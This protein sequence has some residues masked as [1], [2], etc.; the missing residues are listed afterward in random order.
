MRKRTRSRE[1]VLQILY[2]LEIRGN[3]VIDEVDAFCIEQGKEAEVSDFAIK[4]AKGC[5]PK[6][7]EIDQKIIDISKNWELQRMPVVD[8]NILR[9]ACYELFYMDD[10]PPKVSINEAIDLAKKYSTE[11][12]GFFVN[13]VLDK[14]YSINIKNDKKDQKIPTSIEGVDAFDKEDRTG[15]DL[16][17][18]T[19][20]SDGTMSPGQVVKEASKLNLRTIAITDHDNVD[21]V[22]IAQI[23]GDMEGVNVIPAIELSSYY[24]PAD[25]H[26]LGYYI[27]TKNSALIEKLAELR[28]ERVERIKKI[29]KKLRAIGVKVEHQEVFDVS[30]EGSPGRMHIADVLCSKG[31]CAN[32]RETFKKYL[33]DN[34][35][36]F[37]P[38]VALTLKDAIELIISSD[39]IPVLAHPGVTKRDTLIPKMVEYGLQGI[40]VYYPTHQPDAVKR[41]KRI[42]K[43]HDLVITGGSDCHGNRK[44]EIALGSTKIS[45]D[46]VDK[47]K[48]R[49]GNAV[50]ALI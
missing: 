14:I 24:Q 9:L 22:E 50:G 18:H 46:L 11:K 32:I 20:L 10:V 45:D 6:I 42:A 40:E 13:G 25:I 47:I 2:Q 26:L 29:T 17:I 31:Y 48:E 4:L 27:D 35:P 36:A 37:V 7:E 43:K 3:E 23:V 15:A 28:L 39:G 1:I 16:H 49:R 38:K 44:P 33:S 41:Y 8:K 21:A 30:K 19:D 12:S 34:G 5:I